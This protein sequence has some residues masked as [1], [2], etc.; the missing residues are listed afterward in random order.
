V[1]REMTL[2]I[3]LG[4]VGLALLCCLYPLVGALIDG[5][6]SDILLQDQMILGIYFPIGIYLLLA[7]R[8]PSENRSLIL[9]F[10]WSTLAHDAVMVIQAIRAR[11]L[12][13]DGLGLGVIATVCILLLLVAPRKEKAPRVEAAS[14]S[15]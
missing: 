10:V 7:I 3:L 14:A 13:E 15:A 11:S 5:P 1:K 2:K 8:N 4:V 6:K 9:C 12:R